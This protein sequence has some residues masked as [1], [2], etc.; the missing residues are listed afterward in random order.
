MKP[1]KL[2]SEEEL[3]REAITAIKRWEWI[4]AQNRLQRLLEITK[5]STDKYKIYLYAS[6]LVNNRDWKA[7]VL[8]EDVLL[9]RSIKDTIQLLNTNY[10]LSQKDNNMETYKRVEVGNLPGWTRTEIRILRALTEGPGTAE[11]IAKRAG[12][13][14]V[15]VA[16]IST[17][18][19]LV[20]RGVVRKV[21][22]RYEL[23]TK[24][25]GI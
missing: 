11:E 13:R 4:K 6:L 8:L 22:D 17:L 20:K 25:T 12:F 18:E 24:V 21:G 1:L 16:T 14:G 10:L 7:G 9:H 2:K 19:D 5:P 15:G 3:L 23:V